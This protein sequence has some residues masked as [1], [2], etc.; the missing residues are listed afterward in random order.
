MNKNLFELLN[1]VKLVD[2]VVTSALFIVIIGIL[3]TQRKNIKTWLETWRKKRNFEENAMIMIKANTEKIK[4]LESTM[5]SARQTSVDIR[6][7]MYNDLNEVVNDVKTIIVT[8]T[9]LQERDAETKRAE[10][11]HSIEKAY[12]ECCDTKI[13]TDTQ[14]ETLKELIQAYEKHGGTNS[15]VHT[16]VIP[17]MYTWELIKKIP[18]RKDD[19]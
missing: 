13:C 14:F 17:E 19:E 11:K 3:I 7:K 2:V 6:A 16:L 1:A 15:F 9:E 18:E 5:L 12:R 10:I 8:L 4:E